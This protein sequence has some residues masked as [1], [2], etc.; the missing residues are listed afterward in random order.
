MQHTALVIPNVFAA[1]R[2]PVAG[3]KTI[4]PG[5]QIAVMGDEDSEPR[6]YPQEESLMP[7]SLVV[8]RQDF[9]HFT[10]AIDRRMMATRAF[11]QVFAQTFGGLSVGKRRAWAGF[12]LK[13]RRIGGAAGRIPG[14]V[15]GTP[16]YK[17]Q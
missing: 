16:G 5:R 9:Y 13:R 1:K 11:F 17:G 10:L 15:A 12:F 14:V 2:K 6:R 3:R 8:V 4:N 7:H